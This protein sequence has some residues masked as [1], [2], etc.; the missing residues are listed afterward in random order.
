MKHQIG[1]GKKTSLRFDYWLPSGPIAVNREERVIYDSGLGGGAKVADIIHDGGWLWP[2][3]NSVDLME[4]KHEI[5]PNFVPHCNRE[6]SA[7]WSHDRFG[8]FSITDS[9]NL[10]RKE[11][12]VVAW[13]KLVLFPKHVPEHA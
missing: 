11:H 9:W 13:H 4:L 8:K 3:A 5:P 10:L 2:C 1:N 6:D 12:Q 7:S